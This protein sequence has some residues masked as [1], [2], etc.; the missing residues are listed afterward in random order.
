[1][2]GPFQ[3]SEPYS[4]TPL[5]AGLKCIRVLTINAPIAAGGD[6]KPIQAGLAVVD[7][8]QKPKFTTLSYVW[9]EMSEPPKTITVRTSSLSLTDN[10]HAAILALRRKLK[11]F[12]IW[13]DA[14]VLIN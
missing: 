7:L 2:A 9:G 13:V 5:P 11:T 3:I 12:T 8:D 14:S 10:C 1:M 6:S 4:S